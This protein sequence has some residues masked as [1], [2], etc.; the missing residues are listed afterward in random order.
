[1]GLAPGQ[2]F[3]SYEV[4]APLGASRMGEACRARSKTEFG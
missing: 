3:G 4:V 1:M 2:R